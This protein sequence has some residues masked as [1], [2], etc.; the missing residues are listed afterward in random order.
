MHVFIQAY[1]PACAYRSTD[2][3]CLYACMCVCIFLFLKAENLQSAT[4]KG[5]SVGENASI[6]SVAK[7][8][9]SP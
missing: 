4:T 6:S 8:F 2:R 9:L 3:Y 5:E 7:D 1:K